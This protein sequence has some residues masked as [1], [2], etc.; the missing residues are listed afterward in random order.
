MMQKSRK[1]AGLSVE[2][3]KKSFAKELSSLSDIKYP[4]LLTNTY[5]HKSEIHIS[6]LHKYKRRK[7][8]KYENRVV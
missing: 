5:I 3:G 1:Y 7:V 8:E 4:S 6:L 2:R